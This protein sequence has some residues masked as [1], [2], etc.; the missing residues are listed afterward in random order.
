[1]SIVRKSRWST[2]NAA[3][4]TKKQV[5]QLLDKWRH[6]DESAVNELMPLLYD[7]LRALAARQ[8]SA[9]RGSHTLQATA[10]V[11]EAYLRLAGVDVPYQ[12]RKHFFSVAAR[13]MRRVLVDHAKTRNR[14]KRGGKQARVTL[15]EGL[16][17]SPEPGADVAALDEALSRL[18]AEDARKAKVIELHFFGGLT[19]DEVAEALEISPATVHR[20][21]RMAK[22]WLYRE[23]GEET[24]A[25]P[26]SGDAQ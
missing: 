12:D 21:L 4:Q 26:A 5:T 2:M 11:N 17:M 13:T 7:E 18:E 3:A 15:E 25:A 16:V 10:L 14:K 6:G 19:Y 23:L 22:A 1:M 20:E 8:M 9:E 24:G